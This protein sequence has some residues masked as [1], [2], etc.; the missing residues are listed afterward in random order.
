[1]PRETGDRK[2][3]VGRIRDRIGDGLPVNPV[4][5]VPATVDPHGSMP[6][7]YVPALTDKPASFVTALDAVAGRGVRVPDGTEGLRRVL[8]ELCAGESVSSAVVTDEPACEPVPGI[9]AELG[10]SVVR[11]GDPAANAV[12]DLGVTGAVAGLARTGTVVLDTRRAGSRTASLLPRVHLVVLQEAAIVESTGD[13]LRDLARWC[14]DGLPSNLVFVTGP[15]RSADIELQITL[16]V[17]GPK[18]LWVAVLA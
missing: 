16:G 6:V 14:P 10:V 9:L 2:A 18:A 3:F 5:P 13:V 17:H 1:M 11:P 15:S 12:V 4:R 8:T 7:A